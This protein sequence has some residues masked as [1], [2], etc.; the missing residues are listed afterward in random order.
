MKRGL[1]ITFEG[2]DGVGK[3]TQAERLRDYLTQP[4][5]LQDYLDVPRPTV[6]LT[7]EPGGTPLGEK[8]RQLLLD[9]SSR[10]GKRAETLL[11]AADR[12]QHVAEVIKPAL[13]KGQ[14]VICDRYT[15]STV[16]YQVG[17]RE[18]DE[19]DVE[20]LNMW[21]TQGLQP[22]RTYLLDMNPLDRRLTG[23]VDRLEG[24]C[25]EFQN[26]V[27]RKFLDLAKQ[28]PERIMVL[29]GSLSREQVWTLI[30]GDV[31]RI[32]AERASAERLA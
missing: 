20:R 26:R 22:D 5:A 32:L 31:D 14:T 25:F 8:I 10:M 29:D 4:T 16:A 9:P 24:Q 1:F 6:L 19:G 30:K 2:V 17:G 11:F 15:D 7:A 12:A 3:T 21:A 27:R 23:E 18:L 28:Y 13:E